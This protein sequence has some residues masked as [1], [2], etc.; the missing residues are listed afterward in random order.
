MAGFT[1]AGKA[2]PEVGL[3]W[4]VH[5]LLSVARSRPCY[6]SSPLPLASGRK[7]I[8][9]G[10]KGEKERE[11]TLGDLKQMAVCV[12]SGA[13]SSVRAAALTAGLPK[14][15][16]S[17]NRYLSDV[18]KNE[19][20]QHSSAA[21]TM[22]AQINFVKENLEFKEKGNED[23]LARRLFSSDELD[24]FARSLKLFAEM[25]WPL[26]YRQ[27]RVMMS[28]AAAKKFGMQWDGGQRC[29]CSTSYVA[30]FVKSRP[31]LR[32]FKTSHIDPL[33]AKKATAQ[34]IKK[35]PRLCTTNLGIS[36]AAYGDT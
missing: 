22:S 16:R 12:L 31:E 2:T 29:V 30:K 24:F 8:N 19:A 13:A 11:Y 23:L 26:D 35:Y 1:P 7:S 10:K 9:S 18:R 15:E 25:G 32:A 5:L 36:R 14:A 6:D 20:L 34:V 4:C 33:R 3:N 27:I 17:L 28:E 21:E